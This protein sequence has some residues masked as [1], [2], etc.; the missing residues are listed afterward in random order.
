MPHSCWLVS[1]CAGVACVLVLSACGSA[2]DASA[3]TQEAVITTAVTKVPG[4]PLG[5]AS[6]NTFA[7]SINASVIRAQADALVSS[8]LASAGYQ[9][10]NIDEGWWQGARDSAGNIVVSATQ[11][12][13]G[14]SAIAD[15]IH[16][17][18]LKAGI[19]TDAGA[20]GCG[21][22]F[23]QSAPA[24]AGTGSEGHYAADMLQF[25]RWGFDYVKVD[26]CGGSAEGL[27]PQTTYAAISA[28]VRAATATTGRPMTLSICE[29]GQQNPWNW[30][31]GIGQLWRT[32]TD[33]ILFG[34]AA[35][36]A[37]VF[38]NFDKAQHPTQQHTG[39]NNDPD[40]ML[41]GMPGLS[42][43]QSRTH[44]SL[45]AISGAPLLAGNNLTQMSAATA[46]I[47]GN[48]EVIAIDQDALGLQGVKVAED[49]AG[50]Q[51]YGKVLATTGQRAVALVN[52]SSAAA[53]ITARWADL[54]LSTARASVRDIWTRSN[55]G[56]FSTS[57]ARTVNAGEAALLVV[58]GS[59]APTQTYEAE[60]SSNTLS[61]AAAVAACA[62]CSGGS[63]V[64]SVG[65][66][67]S[68]TLR[69]N[70]ISASATGLSVI[71]IAY[72]NGD[73]APRSA[74][75]QVGTTYP[76]VLSFPP[77]GNWNQTGTVSVT[78]ALAKGA[79]NSLTF[80]NSAAWAPDFD[81]FEVRALPGTSGYQLRGVQ[82][83]RCLDVPG[84]SI[85]NGSRT[86]L[87]DCNN[88][89]NQIF[90]LTARKELVVYGNK[91]L[92]AYQN[93]TSNGTAVD[94]WDC[95]GQSNQKWNVNA[96]GT[97]TGVQSGLCL[98]AF[99]AGI[100]NGTQ[101]VLWACGSGQ[102]QRWSIN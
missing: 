4:P 86:E 7:D 76:T 96:D 30:S 95:N 36:M 1:N 72:V 88:G 102:N 27:D 77:T 93:G 24:A 9:F 60:A 52:R 37:N 55:V 18:G 14:M 83:G 54:G 81:A 70:G 67:S 43:A 13:G 31:A 38:G 40:M 64:N 78:V 11:W 100:D 29:W 85:D 21:F 2:P 15:Y 69:I 23:P 53:T 68:S 89:A 98:D 57:Y 87:W 94:V 16:S 91:C 49:T 20:N 46:Q 74:S 25:Q 58:S 92:D 97:I 75:L 47:L 82:S 48:P 12:P 63:R 19:Y 66:A 41:V 56:S 39:Y 80:S 33:I 51:V 3:V 79:N 8:G 44:L 84:N 34:Q 59:E 61:G 10:V 65:N 50:L 62:T 101:L 17:K 45:W 6:W 71:K 35:S 73:S 26:W 28:A 32:S 90:T 42:A 99:N 5:W 22:Y